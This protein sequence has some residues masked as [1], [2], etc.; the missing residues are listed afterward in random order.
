MSVASPDP[1]SVAF[2]LRIIRAYQRTPRPDRPLVYGEEWT[3]L[4]E[5]DQQMLE[6]LFRGAFKVA[7]YTAAPALL[8]AYREAGPD[9]G[10]SAWNQRLAEAW[11]RA[12]PV[13]M[14][15][16]R[17]DSLVSFRK[18]GIAST[19]RCSHCLVFED[20]ED[21]E[22]WRCQLFEEDAGRIWK[23]PE[24]HYAVERWRSFYKVLLVEIRGFFEVIF[25]LSVGLALILAIGW[26]LSKCGVGSGDC[27]TEY[28][29]RANPTI[30]D[31]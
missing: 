23:T 18:I 16:I 10:S 26:A 1:A 30:C 3:E 6:A 2:Y 14:D 19:P 22:S 4:P 29:G 8:K 24:G 20:W 17:K 27:Y 21:A 15:T 31:Y 13:E 11:A 28:D 5:G 9:V 12:A 25:N 7:R